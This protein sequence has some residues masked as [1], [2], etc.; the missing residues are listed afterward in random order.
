MKGLTLPEIETIG[1]MNRYIDTFART[2]RVC[3]EA[4]RVSPNA[5]RCTTDCP[6]SKC[7][8]ELPTGSNQYAKARFVTECRL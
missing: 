3:K 4:L 8:E 5:V 7:I 6:F 2:Y 1:D